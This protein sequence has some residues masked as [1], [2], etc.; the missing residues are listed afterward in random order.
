M[1]ALKILSIAALLGILGGCAAE[2]KE[3]EPKEP[4]A[5]A[6]LD[7]SARTDKSLVNAVHDQAV[8]NA[9]VTQHTFF[10]YHFISNGDALN[11][12]GQRDLGALADY[13]RQHPGD[14]IVRRGDATDELYDAR[15]RH[16]LQGLQ[17]AGVETD[18]V[19]VADALPPGAGM[20]GDRVV[21]ILN[22]KPIKGY[23]AGD[24]SIN[25]QVNDEQRSVKDRPAE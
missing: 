2:P 5:D 12:L 9:I 14:V 20:P 1:T 8:Y 25:A 6:E 23:D 21:K 4:V 17:Q 10:P 13:Y 15:V 19:K 16:V 3:P 7:V 24:G 11:E 22:L 18:R